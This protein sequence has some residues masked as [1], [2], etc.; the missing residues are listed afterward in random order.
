MSSYISSSNNRFYVAA[1]SAYGVASA[2]QGRHRISAVRLKAR[3]EQVQADRR[4]KTGSRS[5]A[6][7]PPGSRKQTTFGL[8][9]YMTA[10]NDPSQ[11]PGHGPLIT[12]AM[13]GAV[14]IFNGGSVASE[15]NTQIAFAAPHGLSVGQAVAIGGEIR[16]VA[17]VMNASAVNVNAPFT[18]T[19]VPGSV[20]S[21]TATYRL[22]NDLPSATIFDYWTPGTS[23]Q[24][25]LA[26]TAVDHFSIKVNGDFHEF[27]FSGAAADLIDSATFAG[28][29]AGLEQFPGEPDPAGFDYTIIPGH[30]GQVWLGS[31]ASQFFT[32]TSA[33][34]RVDN[35]IDLRNREFGSLTPRGIVAGVRKVTSSFSVFAQDDIETKALYEA[36]RQISPIGVML[37][38]GQQPGQLFGLYLK[39]VVPEIPE[40]DDSESRLQWTFKDCRAQ[41]VSDDEIIVAFA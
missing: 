10:W 23:V 17:S 3:Q 31:V 22:A 36:A 15:T 20:A 18:G 9:T 2:I 40:F 16:F 4:D 24:R 12:A 37:Q 13:G 33:E 8:N 14:Q 35:D 41:G 19:V 7:A 11:E 28:G 6:G 21:A 39:S 27:E 1:E 32:L 30:L 26:G 5:Y 25:M 29:Q 38:L 34:I